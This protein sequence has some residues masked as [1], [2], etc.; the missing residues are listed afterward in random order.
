MQSMVTKNRKLTVQLTPVTYHPFTCRDT[1]S[2]REGSSNE[3]PENPAAGNTP[4]FFEKYVLSFD[5]SY[6]TFSI[7]ISEISN[8]GIWTTVALHSLS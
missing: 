6:Y 4:G 7:L 5:V 8:G 1:S 2:S 3:E